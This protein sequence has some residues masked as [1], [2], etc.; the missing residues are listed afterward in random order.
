M[1][2]SPDPPEAVRRRRQGS[3]TVSS[4]L[5]SY[6]AACAAVLIGIKFYQ[7]E[8]AQRHFNETMTL[9]DVPEE[10]IINYVSSNSDPSDLDYYVEYI[11]QP[12]ESKGIGSGIDA[13]DLE[14]YLN[15]T[16]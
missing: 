8:A 12:E 7:Q 15:Y 2:W 14:E 16:L 10:E 9:Q 1:P 6:A 4:W 11:Y 3:T 5:G 13:E